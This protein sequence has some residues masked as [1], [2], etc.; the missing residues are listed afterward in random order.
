MLLF[1][2]KKTIPFKLKEIILNNTVVVKFN[3]TSLRLSHSRIDKINNAS[4]KK[5]ALQMGF[6]KK[7]QYICMNKGKRLS[8]LY[9]FTHDHKN[10]EKLFI[11]SNGRIQGKLTSV[12]NKKMLR[13]KTVEIDNSETVAKELQKILKE[14]AI[15]LQDNIFTK[16]VYPKDKKDT[17]GRDY[18][19]SK[20]FPPVYNPNIPYAHH[21]NEQGTSKYVVSK[22]DNFVALLSTGKEKFST[23]NNFHD[24]EGLNSIKTGLVV[25]PDLMISHNAGI[26]LIDHLNNNAPLPQSVFEIA[27]NDL[28]EL[29]KRQ[30]YLRDIKPA[31]MAYDG[32]Q[33]NFIDVDDRIKAHK[34]TKIT[35]ITK[36]SDPVFK[37]YG[38][39]VIYTPKYITQGLVNHIYESNPGNPGKKTLKQKDIT[40]DLQIADEYAFLMTMITATT[41]DN[42]LKSSIENAK[43]DIMGVRIINRI[44]NKID[45]CSDRQ[46]KNKLTDKLIETQKE[47]NN[48][49]IM[50]KSNKKYFTP[51]L[52]KNIE[53]K[54][55][56]SVKL[57]LT[58]PARYADTAPKTHLADMLLFK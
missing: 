54:H 33:V 27:V 43:V 1:S 21:K 57:L 13:L 15:I 34:I 37:I 44:K 49:G 47:Y 12:I 42:A 51:W 8:D 24:L 50:N 30:G 53:L 3:N 20:N 6:L 22:D 35:K 58:D 5:T 38:K 48:T 36:I 18:Y 52:K 41:K 19:I 4:D 2:G 25:A 31:N 7:I 40:Y 39:E 46:E 11:Q 17:I 14:K 16:I 55:H 29:H 56:E 9:D 26:C 23:K 28:K 10:G 32:K 45:Q